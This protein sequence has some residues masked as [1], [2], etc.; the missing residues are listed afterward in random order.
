MYETPGAP[1]CGF[2]TGKFCFRADSNSSLCI[3]I[4]TDSTH[5]CRLY[6]QRVNFRTIVCQEDCRSIQSDTKPLLTVGG[7]GGGV[8]VDSRGFDVYKHY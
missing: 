4:I 7:W 8:G 3:F 5:I 2:S 6:T 1:L